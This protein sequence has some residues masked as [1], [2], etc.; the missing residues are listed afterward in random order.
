MIRRYCRG[1]ASEDDQGGGVGQNCSL[2]LTAAKRRF[3]D[4]HLWAACEIACGKRSSRKKSLNAGRLCGSYPE[5]LLLL[6]SDSIRFP[7]DFR[8]DFNSATRCIGGVPRRATGT[9]AD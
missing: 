2:Y 7:D 6:Y 9:L 3:S 8:D 4:G 5:T 1:A